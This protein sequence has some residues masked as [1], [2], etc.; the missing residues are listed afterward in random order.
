MFVCCCFFNKINETLWILH[1]HVGLPQAGSCLL[2]G[3]G[4]S[5]LTQIPTT[6]LRGS[7]AASVFARRVDTE[8]QLSACWS[9][10][11]AKK[12]KLYRKSFLLVGICPVS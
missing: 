6:F 9:K 1:P 4:R 2:D 12:V 8:L 10:K 5:H 11:P 3:R 7:E